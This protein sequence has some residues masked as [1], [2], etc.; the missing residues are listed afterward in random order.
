MFNPI[1]F[2]L[3]DRLVTK[4]IDVDVV[5]QEYEADLQVRVESHVEMHENDALHEHVV[6]ELDQLGEIETWVPRYN[7]DTACLYSRLK[8]PIPAPKYSVPIRQG[9]FTATSAWSSFQDDEQQI[10]LSRQ[11][12]L[13]EYFENK[14]AAVGRHITV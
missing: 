4:H 8:L 11:L 5:F 14:K 3:Q 13:L 10:K 9:L 12:V 1:S 2:I 6:V 7:L